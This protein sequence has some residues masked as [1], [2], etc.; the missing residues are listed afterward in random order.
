MDPRPR[1]AAGDDDGEATIEFITVA[2]LLFIPVFYLIATVA[3]LQG[4]TFATQAAATTA[5]RLAVLEKTDRGIVED[6][7]ALS[8]RDFGL[9]K[10]SRNVNL[11]CEPDCAT[12]GAAI[13]VSVTTRVPLPLLPDSFSRVVPLHIPVTATHRGYLERWAVP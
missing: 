3:T 7:V 4:A 12:P 13:E 1:F 10:A 9:D 8:L 5:S 11:R 2:I 6:A